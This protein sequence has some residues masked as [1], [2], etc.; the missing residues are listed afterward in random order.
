MSIFG[1]QVP[2]VLRPSHSCLGSYSSLQ[3]PYKHYSLPLFKEVSLPTGATHTLPPPSC[4]RKY[5]PLTSTVDTLPP[6]F[7]GST[8]P[9]VRCRI[10][11]TP[12]PFQ[13]DTSPYGY[14]IQT[15]PSP[16]SRKYPPPDGDRTHTTPPPVQGSTPLQVPY[17]HYPFSTDSSIL[18]WFCLLVPV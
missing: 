3:L 6:S 5:H 2:S 15:T 16:C 13:R 14:C 10:H 18:T 17:T 11:T 1:L 12:P 8:W 4:P 7:Q 9:F